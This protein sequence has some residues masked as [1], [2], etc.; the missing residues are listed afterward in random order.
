MMNASELQLRKHIEK[1]VVLS[2]DEYIAIK[3]HFRM[4]SFEKHQHIIQEGE[5]VPD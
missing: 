4:Q 3:G 5:A 1:T 2:D